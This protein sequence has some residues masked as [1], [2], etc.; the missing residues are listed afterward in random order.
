[1]HLIQQ[2]NNLAF[3]QINKKKDQKKLPV[4]FY[5]NGVEFTLISSRNYLQ[6]VF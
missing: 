4:F 5:N 6:L 1:M 3:L 2:I